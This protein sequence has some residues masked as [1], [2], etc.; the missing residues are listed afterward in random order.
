MKVELVALSK[1]SAVTETGSADEFV[2]YCARVSNPFG[3]LGLS[4]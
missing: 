1:P 4:V 2:A 3:I